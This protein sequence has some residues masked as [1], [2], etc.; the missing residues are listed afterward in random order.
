MLKIS[1]V[2]SASIA[3]NLPV[4]TSYSQNGWFK[5]PTLDAK[6]VNIVTDFNADQNDKI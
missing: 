3:G 6:Q 2:Q 1:G 5:D 4:E